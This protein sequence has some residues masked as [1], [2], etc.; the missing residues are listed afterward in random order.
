MV[1]DRLKAEPRDPTP[2]ELLRILDGIVVALEEL[3]EKR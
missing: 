2:S 1:L 3:T